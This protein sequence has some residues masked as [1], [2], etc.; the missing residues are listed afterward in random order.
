MLIQLA[1][2]S[3][4]LHFWQKFIVFHDN[5]SKRINGKQHFFLILSK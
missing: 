3:H 1:S 5:F 4:N 2:R